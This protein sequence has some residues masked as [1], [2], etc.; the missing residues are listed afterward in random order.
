[1][2]T[3]LESS[4]DGSG[5]AAWSRGWG[6]S[7]EQTGR[8]MHSGCG[9]RA[10]GPISSC[11]GRKESIVHENRFIGNFH[12]ELHMTGWRGLPFLKMSSPACPRSSHSRRIGRMVDGSGCSVAVWLWK[13]QANAP[14]IPNAIGRPSMEVRVCG[15][16]KPSKGVRLSAD[17]LVRGGGEKSKCGRAGLRLRHLGPFPRDKPRHGCNCAWKV[18]TSLLA[19]RLLGAE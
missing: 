3:E 11:Q 18:W 10:L 12:P 13:R 14:S 2:Y 15:I 7:C 4:R 8:L 5:I 19:A 6:N 9:E 17:Q 16:A 1:M